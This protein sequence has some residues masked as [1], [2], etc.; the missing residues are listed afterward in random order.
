MTFDSSQG[1]MTIESGNP[2]S[3]DSMNV[4][5]LYNLLVKLKKDN[6]LEVSNSALTSQ[7]YITTN[8]MNSLL[9][10][11]DD[12]ILNLEQNLS[13]SSSAGA[14]SNENEFNDLELLENDLIAD[15]NMCGNGNS[16]NSLELDLLDDLSLI[17]VQSVAD[18][19]MN[20]N[21]E[22]QAQ[23]QEPQQMTNANSGKFQCQELCCLLKFNALDNAFV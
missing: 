21:I 10:P 9:Q 13:D 12:P 14:V 22:Q 16:S 11:N 15:A 3:T 5:N 6:K 17:P 18:F 19:E 1:Y 7:F 4:E 8:E 2:I 23:E 20:K